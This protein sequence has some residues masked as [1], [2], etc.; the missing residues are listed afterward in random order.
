MTNRKFSGQGLRFLSKTIPKCILLVNSDKKSSWLW[1][2]WQ[3]SRLR[4]VR[5]ELHRINSMTCNLC[6]SR[7]AKQRKFLSFNTELFVC[8][9]CFIPTDSLWLI[10]F[11]FE[12]LFLV[13]K[14]LV[15]N[16]RRK[17]SAGPCYSY[18]ELPFRE[19]LCSKQWKLFFKSRLVTSALG[20]VSL[21]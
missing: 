15:K 11:Q 12:L 19:R 4:S 1:Q 7:T 6:L 8:L 9:L 13:Y 10:F 20:P 3:K 2:F 5:Y 18:K 17:P 14:A 16:R 21:E